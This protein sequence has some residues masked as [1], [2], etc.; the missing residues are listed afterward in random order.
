MK[1]AEKPITG[2]E[3]IGREHEPVLAMEYMKMV[4]SFPTRFSCTG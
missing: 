4:I 1:Q 2:T 3:F